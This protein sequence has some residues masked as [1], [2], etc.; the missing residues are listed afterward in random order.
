M[1]PRP[2][3]RASRP[4]SQALGLCHPLRRGARDGLR[5]ASLRGHLRGHHAAAGGPLPPLYIDHEAHGAHAAR[6]AG[7]RGAAAADVGRLG[8]QDGPPQGGH[9]AERSVYFLG[10]RRGA[11]SVSS[12]GD[13]ARRYR[14]QRQMA[15]LLEKHQARGAVRE[16]PRVRFMRNFD[17]NMRIGQDRRSRDEDHRP[18]TPDTIA[19]LRGE[20]TSS[21]RILHRRSS[22]GSSSPSRWRRCPSS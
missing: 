19:S 6:Q 12:N 11:A 7:A 13:N 4:P 16:I 9:A 3:R 8:G 14:Y 15:A 20:R 10:A 18:R 1:M 5:R 17:E 22:P 2:I 21:P